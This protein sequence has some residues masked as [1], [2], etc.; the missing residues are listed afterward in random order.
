MV[1]ACGLSSLSLILA[2][3]FF[4]Y[5]RVDVN[6]RP[7]ALVGLPQTPVSAAK[8]TQ[9]LRGPR[10]RLDLMVGEQPALFDTGQPR[11]SLQP[12]TKERHLLARLRA[13]VQDSGEMTLMAWVL[14]EEAPGD[15]GVIATNAD[16]ICGGA[17]QPGAYA[18]ALDRRGLSFS[19]TDRS[20]GC[21][22]MRCAD[23]HSFNP[24]Q[25][26]HVAVAASPNEMS[27]YINGVKVRPA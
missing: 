5:S 24:H 8:I 10:T 11:S 22:E 1:R 21:Q 4:L 20:G 18:L 3:L 2:G 17:E 16:I 26:T 27:M 25:W 23:C 9:K 7:S 19:W 15:R 13:P 6:L 12:V 14:A